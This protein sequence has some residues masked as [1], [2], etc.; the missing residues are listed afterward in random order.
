MPP[1]PKIDDALR[2]VGRPEIERQ[3]DAEHPRRTER[4]VRVSGE[5]EVDLKSIGK[6]GTPAFEQ[7]EWRT[8]S[9]GGESRRRE[10]R[11]VIGDDRFL[12]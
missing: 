9:S 2:L 10:A 7:R 8:G 5:V 3:H 11:H 1:A 12:E 4:H 6:C